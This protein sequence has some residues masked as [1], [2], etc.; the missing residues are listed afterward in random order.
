MDEEDVPATN[1][2]RFLLPL[3]KPHSGRGRDRHFDMVASEI[4]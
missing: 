1:D 3:R 4:S 2:N